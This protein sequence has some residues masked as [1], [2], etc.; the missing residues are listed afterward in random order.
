MAEANDGAVTGLLARIRAGD[1]SAREAIVPLVYDELRRLAA[2]YLKHERGN[3]TLQPTALVHEA[4][5][6]LVDQRDVAWQNRAHFMGVAAIVMRRVLVNH[7]RER[8]AAKRGDGL[9]PESLTVVGDVAAPAP[10]DL[11]ALDRALDA[12]AAL[13]A[14]K[15]RVVE[16]KFFGGLTTEETAEAVDASVATVER[17]WSFARAWLYDH[18]SQ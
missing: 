16:L 6:R 3:H 2:S 1:A 4:Y 18:L 14:R 15:C 5:L 12:L 11:L 13:D 8:A 17:D 9:V 7:A 10:V